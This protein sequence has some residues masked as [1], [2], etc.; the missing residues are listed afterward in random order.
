ME[1]ISLSL[2]TKSFW[3][4]I[5]GWGFAV[6]DA[7]VFPSIFSERRNGA[8][9]FY[10]GPYLFKILHKENLVEYKR[11]DLKFGDKNG[12]SSNS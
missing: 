8:N 1:L 6:R 3:I 5:F 4:R 2:S 12:S 10:I 11:V 9:H 7:R